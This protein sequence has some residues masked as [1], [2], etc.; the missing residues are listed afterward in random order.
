MIKN[1]FLILLVISGL[2]SCD[3]V[4]DIKLE[5]QTGKPVVVIYR[6]LIEIA[7]T[8]SKIES[9]DVNGVKY[10]KVVL[11]SGE[12]MRIGNVVARYSPRAEDVELDF[13]EV[14]IDNDTMKL[15]G[16]K[17]IFSAIQKVDKLDWR[18]IIKDK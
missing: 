12:V 6:P 14:Y 13:L 5:N 17:S 11:D 8:G 4:H 7:P 9:F 1:I 10:A 2:S 3:P 16:K 15:I 18:L